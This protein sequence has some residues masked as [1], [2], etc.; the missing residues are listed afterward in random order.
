MD[1]AQ[2]VMDHRFTGACPD[3][4]NGWESRDPDCGACRALN[5]LAQQNEVAYEY[6]W[7]G[8][9]GE[10][11]WELDAYFNSPAEADAYLQNHSWIRMQDGVLHRRRAAGPWEQITR[12]AA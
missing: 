11:D 8:A 3:A 6:T 9:D 4:V 1:I 10:D 12:V 2:Q 7:A 5:T